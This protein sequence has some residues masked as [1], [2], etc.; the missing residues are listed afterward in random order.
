VVTPY[1]V[2]PVNANEISLPTDGFRVPNEFQRHLL[3]R[4]NDGETGAVRPGPTV[5]EAPATGPD[6]SQRED[7]PGEPGAPAGS[8]Q[9]A[10]DERAVPGFSFNVKGN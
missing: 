6:L 4:E 3:Y 8:R 2:R 10:R 1:L 5:R 9:A 7:Q